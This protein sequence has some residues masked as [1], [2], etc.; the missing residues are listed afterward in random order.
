MAGDKIEATA[1][2]GN[3]AVRFQTREGDKI[4]TEME[5]GD[6][7]ALALQLIKAAKTAGYVKPKRGAAG[8]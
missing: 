2:F 1:F 3:V 5:P 8:A 7:A 6:A 4:I